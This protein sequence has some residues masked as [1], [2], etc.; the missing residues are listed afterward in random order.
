MVILI[1]IPVQIPIVKKMEQL[2]IDAGHISAGTKRGTSHE[3][4]LLEMGWQLLST[5]RIIAKGIKMFQIK[6]GALP[7]YLGHISRQRGT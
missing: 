7:D 3:Q 6:N 2:Q 1:M 4:I 5:R